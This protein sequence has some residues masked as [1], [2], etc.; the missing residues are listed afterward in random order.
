MLAG[1]IGVA[2]EIR[3]GRKSAKPAANDMRPH[4]GLLA[5]RVRQRRPSRKIGKRS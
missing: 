1:H 2:D 3:G 5:Q 4:L